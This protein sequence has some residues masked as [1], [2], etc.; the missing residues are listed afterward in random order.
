MKA[1]NIQWNKLTPQAVHTAGS[2]RG[3]GYDINLVMPDEVIDVRDMLLM[4]LGSKQ[5]FEE[6]TSI[7][8]LMNVSDL[9]KSG[10]ALRMIGISRG[11]DEIFFT[12]MGEAESV[13][14][15]HS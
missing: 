6:P 15:T 8:N 4:W 12:A 3:M 9:C 1:S 2:H 5:R 11:P 14:I 10:N 13:S 7:V